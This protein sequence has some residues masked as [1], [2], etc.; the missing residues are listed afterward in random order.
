MEPIR[1]AN[2]ALQ[3]AGPLAEAGDWQ[4]LFETMTAALER[5]GSYRG[6]M[7]YYLLCAAARL[8][9]K[10]FVLEAL[11]RMAGR[12]DWYSETIFRQTPSFAPFQGDPRFEALLARHRAVMDADPGLAS[13]TV[14]ERPAAGTDRGV[15]VMVLHGNGGSTLD[16]APRWRGLVGLGCTLAMP[17]SG[18]QILMRG[19]Y[20]WDDEEATFAT[21]RAFIAE[22]DLPTGDRL[23]LGGFSLG[24]GMALKAALTGVIPCRGLVLFAPYIPDEADWRSWMERAPG[25]LRGTMLVGRDDEQPELLGTIAQALTDAGHPFVLETMPGGHEYPADFDAW[26]GRAIDVVLGN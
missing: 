18:Q 16:E 15:A 13:P 1:S 25:R 20:G 10:D 14:L 22:H 19:T 26:L 5:F 23:V 11:D 21:M 3:R 17:E 7:E 9:R 2:D 12:G 4:G 24:G 6:M 8:D